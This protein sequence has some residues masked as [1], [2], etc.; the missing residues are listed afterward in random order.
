MPC[1]ETHAGSPSED[2]RC[3]CGR[4]VARVVP[5][6]IQLKCR[7]CKRTLRVAL[8]SGSSVEGAEFEVALEREAG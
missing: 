3:V 4:L 6:G 5:G 2:C 7:R 1:S 8:A